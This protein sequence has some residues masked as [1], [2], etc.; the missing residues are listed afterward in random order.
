M[1]GFVE[2]HFRI[3]LLKN[4][5]FLRPLADRRAHLDHLRKQFEPEDYRH[6]G[7]AMG[8]ANLDLMAQVS[9]DFVLL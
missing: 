7:I 6:H 1:Y 8:G 9:F 5:L 2:E 3:E 4:D